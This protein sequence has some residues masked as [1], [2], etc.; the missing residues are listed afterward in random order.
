MYDDRIEFYDYI[1]SKSLV[2]SSEPFFDYTNDNTVNEVINR[3]DW[4]AIG[5]YYKENGYVVIDNF[6][7]EDV[8]H[9]LR[10][11]IL[12]CN[13]RDDIYKD[14]AAVLIK[15]ERGCNW[16]PLLSNI[17]DCF[18]VAFKEITH[19][20]FYRGWA[21][22]FENE[23]SGA[24]THA[25]PSYVTANLWCTP[26]DRMVMQEGYNGFDLWKFTPPPEWNVND[27]VNNYNIVD[28]LIKE[29]NAEK[30]SIDYKFNRVT[31]FDSR[32]FHRTQP[33]KSKPGY[34]NRRVSYAFLFGDEEELLREGQVTRT[35]S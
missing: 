9:R 30:I 27:W 4:K 22:V 19:Y 14:F 28:D 17:T 8:I 21:L 1:K 5:K 15:R 18:N 24:K 13:H 2:Y 3:L 6:L 10:E 35:V 7:K 12:T 32:L 20:N 31:I 23:S 26:E 34:Q 29:T 33:V 25:D 16:F 11:A